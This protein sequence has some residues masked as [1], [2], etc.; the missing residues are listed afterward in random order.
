MFDHIFASQ[1]TPKEGTIYLWSSQESFY[2]SLSMEN[3]L[4]TSN[5]HAL[6]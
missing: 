4:A 1:E 2:N 6:S 5:I 3:D